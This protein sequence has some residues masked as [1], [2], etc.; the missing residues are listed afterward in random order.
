MKLLILK[1]CKVRI[2]VLKQDR[3]FYCSFAEQELPKDTVYRSHASLSSFQQG[4]QL[5]RLIPGFLSTASSLHLFILFFFP[6]PILI[7]SMRNPLFFQNNDIQS[8]SGYLLILLIYHLCALVAE[9][10]FF[11]F[12]HLVIHPCDFGKAINKTEV[13]TWP[14]QDTMSWTHSSSRS[15]CWWMQDEQGPGERV[16]SYLESLAMETHTV[17]GETVYLFHWKLTMRMIKPKLL[18]LYL[19]SESKMKEGNLTAY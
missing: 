10:L 4:C 3:A 8:W 9:P 5:V 11:F 16:S 14:S 13:E 7:M 6:F 18:W 1:T 15:G 2:L 19:L 12:S 17:A